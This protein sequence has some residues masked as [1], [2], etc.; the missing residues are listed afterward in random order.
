ME[1]NLEITQELRDKLRERYGDIVDHIG[2][3]RL[4]NSDDY[5]MSVIFR[6]RLRRYSPIIPSID[7]FI[8]EN[9]MYKLC[10][11]IDKIVFDRKP[12]MGTTSQ[13]SPIPN[14]GIRVS[15][16]IPEGMIFVSPETYGEII[17]NLCNQNL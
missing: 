1:P 9:S 16:R 17:A 12:N 14:I 10:D 3:R 7:K 15:N 8:I 6:N 4:R 13:F 5:E 2:M 11:Y